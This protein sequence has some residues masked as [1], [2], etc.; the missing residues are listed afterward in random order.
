MITPNRLTAVRILLALVTSSILVFSHNIWLLIVSLFLFIV[1]AL[2]D[3]YDGILARKK[4][5]ET[6]LGAILDP[7]A[8]KL[9]VLLTLLAFA[10][11]GLFAAWW[12]LPIAIREIAV[13][14][15]RLQHRGDTRIIR[16]DVAGKWK[17][18]TQL[19]IIGVAYVGA[20]MLM[21]K[22]GQVYG[23]MIRITLNCALSVTL[24]LTLWSG[25]LFFKKAGVSFRRDNWKEWVATCFF[26]GYS[27]WIPG[28]LGS[29]A[30][31][32]FLI[33]RS[34]VQLQIVLIIIILVLGLKSTTA[35]IAHT[36]NQDPR[37]VVIDEVCGILVTFFAVPV[38]GRT[39]MVGFVL[40]RLFDIWKPLGIRSVEKWGG[41]WGV[42]A[43]DLLA[44]LYANACLQIFFRLLWR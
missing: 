37:E 14:L 25:Y 6:E 29:A 11:R 38:D 24:A 27:R 31:L 13:T 4:H 41:A 34:T 40:F 12:I 43:D 30:G 8:D 44:G 1:A 17:T 5:M 32:L 16:A 18:G 20:I 2:T 10:Y 36:G 3:L 42:M 33:D 23:Q 26:I 28:T 19:S 21:T 7:V 35:Q 22:E 15:V 9:L 39:L